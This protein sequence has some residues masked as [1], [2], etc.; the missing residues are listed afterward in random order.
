MIYRKLAY[1]T[2]EH[3]LKFALPQTLGMLQKSSSAH[4][5]QPDFLPT[6]A[7]SVCGNPHLGWKMVF[8]GHIEATPSSQPQKVN[9]F[10]IRP[11]PCKSQ[12]P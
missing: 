11:K 2:P 10:G 4:S 5:G 7:G 12:A 3:Q 6:T 1:P 8:L 9:L